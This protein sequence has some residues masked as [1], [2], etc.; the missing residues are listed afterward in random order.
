MEWT[1]I[2]T[3][4]YGKIVFHSIPCH[5]LSTT[6]VKKNSLQ[7]KLAFFFLQL[8]TISCFI[9]SRDVEVEAGS[10]SGGIG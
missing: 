2:A 10:V 4:E 1:K 3:M 7:S 6:Q 9:L 8:S 5:A